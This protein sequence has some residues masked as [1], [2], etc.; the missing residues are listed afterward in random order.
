M[1]GPDHLASLEP[2]ELKQMVSSIRNVKIALG[3]RIKEPTLSEKKNILAARRSIFASR[4]INKEEL[5][6]EKT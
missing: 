2:N 6:T 3:S 5:F 1:K 4:K